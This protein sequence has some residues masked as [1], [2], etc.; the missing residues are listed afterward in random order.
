MGFKV[1]DFKSYNTIPLTIY[2]YKFTSFLVIA[3]DLNHLNTPVK[4]VV[5]AFKRY[6]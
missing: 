3:L 6:S 2:L 4:T 1:V 5:F